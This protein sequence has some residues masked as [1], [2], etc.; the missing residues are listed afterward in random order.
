MGLKW[1]SSGSG[2][3]SIFKIVIEIRVFLFGIKAGYRS[4]KGKLAFFVSYSGG[5]CEI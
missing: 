4:N 3:V 2:D 5:L 1:E